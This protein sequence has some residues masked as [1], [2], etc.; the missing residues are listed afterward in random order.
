MSINPRLH[1]QSTTIDDTDRDS[2]NFLIRLNG[3]SREAYKLVRATIEKEHGGRAP[4]NPMV[5]DTLM[6]C[7]LK[8]KWEANT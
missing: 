1:R 4:S 3:P 8:D 2:Y 7:F 5:I 6:Q